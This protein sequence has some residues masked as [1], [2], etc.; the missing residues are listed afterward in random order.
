MKSK[1]IFRTFI[2]STILFSNLNAQVK[3]KPL[4]VGDTV[5]DFIIPKI[6]NY[7]VQSARTADFANQ[8]VILDYWTTNCSGCIESF[9]RL[10][11]L[12]KRFGD[13]IR[14]LPVTYQ[15][16]N[17]IERFWKTNKYT[18][19]LSLPTIVEGHDFEQLFPHQGV[20][21]E[22]WIYK[23]KVIGITTV[24]YVDVNNI[25][26]ILSGVTV[27]FPLKYDFYKFDFSKPIFSSLD[28]INTNNYAK[29]KGY[30]PKVRSLGFS[31]GRGIQRNKENGTVRC[32]SINEPIYVTYL[33][34][35]MAVLGGYSNLIKPTARVDSNQVIWEVRDKSKY[36]HSFKYS[37][38]PTDWVIERSISYESVRS[39]KG[40]DDKI[41]YRGAIRDLDSLLSL[42]VR[43]EKRFETVWK[44][45]R[46]VNKTLS[47]GGMEGV[48]MS[49]ADLIDLYND[50]ENHV[51]VFDEFKRDTNYWM[52]TLPITSSTNIK[53]LNK[54]LNP[55]GLTM[56]EEKMNVDKLIFSEVI[57]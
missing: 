52:G 31:G 14:I 8:L 11:A 10:A 3:K 13:K 57:R 37:A 55:L 23:M 28:K 48:G 16:Q 53:T 21:H 4:T 35:W 5:P 32:Y 25:N 40:Q 18:K 2:L 12:Q 54:I 56:V 27:T 7:S 1:K 9:P 49:I 45:K 26:K 19:S 39:D 47:K 20:P 50:D 38:Y 30:I 44:L 29:I 24:D 46:I 51:Y 36:M 43:W 17:L 15:D 34:N 42:H 22:V 41:V 6:V 33:L